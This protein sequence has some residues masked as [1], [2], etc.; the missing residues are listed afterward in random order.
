MSHYGELIGQYDPFK[1]DI[2][3]MFSDYFEN[4]KLTKIKDVNGCSMYL[5]KIN[6]LLGREFRY[7][8]VFVK[9]DIFPNGHTSDLSDLFWLSLQTRTLVEN[10]NVST[11]N[12]ISR[13]FNPL[14]KEIILEKKEP[15]NY[16]YKCPT[17]NLL[18]VLLIG[19]KNGEME[20][21]QRGTIVTAIETYSTVITLN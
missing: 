9:Q 8:I 11:H 16:Y 3:R 6:S 20:Y 1:Q 7:L 10:H 13:R 12:Y 14:M 17:Y 18:S 5:T 21:Q 19:K 4:P 2:Y 15:P